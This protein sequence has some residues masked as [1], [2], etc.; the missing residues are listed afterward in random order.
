VA[1]SQE[2]LENVSRQATHANQRRGKPLLKWRR[3]MT[4]R[5]SRE[6][7]RAIEN[8]T[9][10]NRDQFEP[11]APCPV[12]KRAVERRE[13][14]SRNKWII[15]QCCSAKCS[16][17]MRALRTYGPRPDY[18]IKDFP[19]PKEHALC[20]HCGNPVPRREGES[21]SRW[22]ARST[23]SSVCAKAKRVAAG[24]MGAQASKK[25]VAQ[26]SRDLAPRN[27]GI[28]SATNPVFEQ[29]NIEPDDNRGRVF[30]PPTLVETRVAGW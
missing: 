28:G 11:H 15:R 19:P 8:L 18:T 3:E 1:G 9:G 12:C 30:P 23:C 16:G 20:T 21:P 24:L 27:D 7:T 29:H 10:I 17:Q 6:I 14:E 5:H 26:K 4:A 25:A 13:G 2:L 22:H